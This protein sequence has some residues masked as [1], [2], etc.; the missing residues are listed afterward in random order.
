MLFA[1]ALGFL[2][3]ISQ[4]SAGLQYKGADISSLI[5]L[6]QSGKSYKSSSGA[7][8]PFEKLLASSG[9]NAARQRVWV[10]P[11]NGVY[12]LNYNLQLAQRV[13]SAGMKVYLDLHFSDTWADPG[14][15]NYLTHMMEA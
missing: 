13:Q 2:S 6:E 5:T 1:F 8:T 14:H 3:L 15:R 12:N 4:V 10:N 11:S 7:V 9:A